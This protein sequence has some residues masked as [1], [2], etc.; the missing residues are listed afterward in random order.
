MGAV[1]LPSL[2]IGERVLV[3]FG[4]LVTFVLAYAAVANAAITSTAVSSALNVMLVAILL[5]TAGTALLMTRTITHPIAQMLS[6]IERFR[7]DRSA[8]ADVGGEDEISELAAPFDR[9]AAEN[10]AGHA[11]LERLVDQRT[12][13]LRAANRELESFAYS[14]SHDLRAPLR[15]IEG[16]TNEILESG[17]HL[18]ERSQ[19]DFDRVRAAARN[20][21]DLIDDLLDLSRLTRQTMSIAPVD[22]TALAAAIL[23]QLRAGEGDRDVAIEIEPGMRADADERLLRVALT[24]LLNNAWKFTCKSA[25]ARI[26]IGTERHGNDMVFVIEDNG[27][28]FDMRHADKLFAPFQRLHSGAEFEGSGIGLATVQR[29]IAR[30]GGSVWAEGAPGKGA[31]FRFMLAACAAQT[32]G[33][34]V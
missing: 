4:V 21:G 32:K 1:R 13:E 7:D 5:A 31:T 24:N 26:R 34:A 12:A 22:V 29:V 6:A 33:D 25:C 2:A 10:A 19:H 16:F 3:G 23:A 15:A 20:M 28:G 17:D 8:R 18:S 27:A 11:D 9:V 14:V 30:H